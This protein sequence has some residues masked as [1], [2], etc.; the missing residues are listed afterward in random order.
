MKAFLIFFVWMTT[1]Q[2]A[3]ALRHRKLVRAQAEK[4]IDQEYIVVFREG[5]NSKDKVATLSATLADCSFRFT[6]EDDQFQGAAI[7]NMSAA[8]LSTML[9]DPDVLFIEEVS[10]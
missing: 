9:E 3:D 2:G 8:Q 1:V 10:L 6:Y 4:R 5:T 7:G